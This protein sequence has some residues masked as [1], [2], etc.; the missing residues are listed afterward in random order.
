MVKRF[1]KKGGSWHE[2]PYTKEEE[3]DLYTRWGRGPIA[4]LKKAEAPSQGQTAQQPAKDPS[5]D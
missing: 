1:D 2:P 3:R 5:Q 4:V